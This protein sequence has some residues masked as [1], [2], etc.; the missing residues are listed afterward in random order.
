MQDICWENLQEEGHGGGACAGLS[1]QWWLQTRCVT[2][3]WQGVDVLENGHC[4]DS[5]FPV[6]FYRIQVHIPTAVLPGFSLIGHR[7]VAFRQD[8]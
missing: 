7:E 1:H 5:L 3:W 8:V 4:G 6:V 2:C